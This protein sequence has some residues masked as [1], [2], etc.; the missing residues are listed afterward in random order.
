[1]ILAPTSNMCLCI[2][3]SDDV[4]EEHRQF[5]LVRA[6]KCP[7]SSGGGGFCIILH[8]SACRRGYNPVRERGRS[9][10]VSRC[11]WNVC[12]RDSARDLMRSKRVTCSWGCLV[13]FRCSW[14]LS[15]FF[16][17]LERS[18]HAPFIASRRCRVTRCWYGVQS[19][20]EKEPRGHGEAL[21]SGDVV[22]TIEAWRWYFWHCYYMSRHVCHC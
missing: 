20:L 11:E 1:M 6:E 10:Q 2:E 3:G 18:M 17:S 4:Q 13:L 7:T 21:S 5:I 16:L 9:S 22:C 8:R 19:L 14:F 15:S 12:V